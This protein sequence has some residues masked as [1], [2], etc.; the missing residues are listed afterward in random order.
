MYIY[1]YASYDL[2]QVLYTRIC[3][4]DIVEK[5][6]YV[7]GKSPNIYSTWNTSSENIFGLFP[8]IYSD[9]LTIVVCQYSVK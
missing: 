7:F 8:N 1:I 6:E 4:T 9:F 3:R 5:S 2:H